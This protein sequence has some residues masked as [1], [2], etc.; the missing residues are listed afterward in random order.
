VLCLLAIGVATVAFPQGAGAP[1][2]PAEL[3]ARFLA[4]DEHP[5]VSYRALRRLTAS[6]RGGRTQAAI[7]AWTTLDPAH[8]FRFEVVAEEGSAL[9]RNKVLLAALQ[10]EQQ[11]VASA[12]RDQAALVPANYEF[13]DASAAPVNLVKV[14]VRPRRKHVMLVD[15]AVFLEPQSADL[16]RLEGQ[17]SRRPSMWTRRV[18]VFRDYARINGVHVPIAMQSTADVLVVGASSFSMTY[19]YAEINGK[20][21]EQP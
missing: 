6:T 7:E 21:V 19:R 18:M 8:G 11:A 9:I 17:L 3:I 5:L 13:L 10:A 1:V 20:P 12:A 16:I 2:A 15:G 4:P 14:V